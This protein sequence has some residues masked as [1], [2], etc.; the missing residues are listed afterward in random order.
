MVAARAQ[1]DCLRIRRPSRPVKHASTLRD[2]LVSYLSRPEK[3]LKA[4]TTPHS[5]SEHDTLVTFAGW[6]S[7]LCSSTP[8]G[9]DLRPILR[10]RAAVRDESSETTAARRERDT[11]L[12]QNHPSGIFASREKPRNHTLSPYIFSTNPLYMLV[13]FLFVNIHLKRRRARC[14]QFYSATL[15]VSNLTSIK[16]IH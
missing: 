12:S 6:L 14:F 16:Q 10:R 2:G 7:Q 1:I 15:R 4:S 11:P 8:Y 9:V 5:S 13:I 3:R